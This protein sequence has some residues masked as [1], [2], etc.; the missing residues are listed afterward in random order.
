MLKP[1]GQVFVRDYAVGDLAEGKLS[2]R[3]NQRCISS[4]FYV[5]GDGT[6][7]F[8]FSEVG[9]ILSIFWRYAGFL[10]KIVCKI[11]ISMALCQDIEGMRSYL[12]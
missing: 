7:A 5:R 12:G 9:S 10:G 4:H 6:R 3:A 2:Q 8:Y 1:G 11:Q